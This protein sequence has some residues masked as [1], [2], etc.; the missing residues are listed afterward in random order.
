[1]TTFQ[2]LMHDLGGNTPNYALAVLMS[3]RTL[4]YYLKRK[5]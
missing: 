5:G 4:H 2:D 3:G 1:M